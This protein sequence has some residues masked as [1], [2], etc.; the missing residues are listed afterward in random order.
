MPNSPFGPVE[1]YP[2]ETLPYVHK[3]MLLFSL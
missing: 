2:I 3:Y 1:I